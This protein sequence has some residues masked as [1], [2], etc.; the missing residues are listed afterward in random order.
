MEQVLKIELEL[1]RK[2]RPL[3]LIEDSHSGE[4]AARVLRMIRRQAL[5]QAAQQG[6]Q[7]ALHH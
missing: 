7:H 6:E 4:R 5:A 3:F 1:A 2:Y